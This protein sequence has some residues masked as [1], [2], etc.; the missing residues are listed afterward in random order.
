MSLPPELPASRHL[1]AAL[2]P[3][4]P[5]QDRE[6]PMLLFL[7]ST[8]VLIAVA[9]DLLT[10]VA[11]MG[12]IGGFFPRCIENCVQ[13]NLTGITTLLRITTAAAVISATGS[14]ITGI[15]VRRYATQRPETAD[16]ARIATVGIRL[17]TLGVV[18][19][20]MALCWYLFFAVR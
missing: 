17:S 19:W 1:D 8:G 6:H 2:D 12:T 18:V 10:V 15:L 16:M 14:L 7:A 20:G 13:P 4:A 3:Q 5:S 11:L 9:A